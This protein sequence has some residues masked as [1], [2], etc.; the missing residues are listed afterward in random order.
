MNVLLI[1]GGW[2]SERDVSLSGGKGIHKALVELGH[3]VSVYDPALSLDGLMEAAQGKDFAFINLHGSPGEDGLIQAMLERAGCPYQGAGPAASILALNKAAAKALFTGVG[4]NTAPYRL[5][6]ELPERDWQ[7]M[8]S[9]P[10]FIKANTGGSSLHMERVEKPEDL[11]AALK[12]LFMVN[13]SYLVES[14][15]SGQEITCGIL[16]ELKPATQEEQARALPPILIKPATGKIFDY[17]SKYSPGGAEEICPAPI[18]DALTEKIQNMALNAHLALGCEGYSRA[19]FIV[20]EP[21]DA[22]AEPVLLEVNTLPGMTPTSLL[23]QEAA[24]IGLSFPQL[25]Q[26]LIDLGLARAARKG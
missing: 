22:A 1:A 11:R 25:I 14:A 15:V 4:L 20:P 10:L 2:S 8:L 12:R 24:A 18:P 7:P 26:R 21:L 3:T 17:T 5:L 13:S 16:G 9:Y 23:P 6:N 19:D